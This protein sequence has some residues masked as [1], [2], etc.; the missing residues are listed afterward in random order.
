M[1]RWIVRV[2]IKWML[3]A[4]GV[5]EISPIAALAHQYSMSLAIVQPNAKTEKVEVIIQ[6]FNHDL[7]PALSRL[8][9]QREDSWASPTCDTGQVLQSYTKK[10]FRVYDGHQQLSWRWVGVERKVHQ[11]YIYLELAMQPHWG[12]WRFE[13]ELLKDIYPSQLNRVDVRKNA[14]TSH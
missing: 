14:S 8:C 11:S 6:L 10:H 2:I 3:I 1:T 5:V 4:L 9:Q 7:E 13:H 12:N